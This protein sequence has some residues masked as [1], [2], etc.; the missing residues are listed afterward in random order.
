MAVKSEG[1]RKKWGTIEM[2]DR[3]EER[4]RER[5]EGERGEEG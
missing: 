4:S 2:R 3:E 5:G 1:M